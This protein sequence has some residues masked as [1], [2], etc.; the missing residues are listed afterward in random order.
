MKVC[1]ACWSTNITIKI[2]Q[3]DLWICKECGWEGVT[4]LEFPGI[5]DETLE[6]MKEIRELE[7]SG[8][9]RKAVE[10]KEELKKM[11]EKNER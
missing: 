9:K 2:P 4:V 10:K 6:K 1:P 7:A 5:S 3:I 8:E 11:M